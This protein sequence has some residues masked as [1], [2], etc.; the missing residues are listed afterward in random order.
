MWADPD[1]GPTEA[2]K[3]G[4]KCIY[5]EGITPEDLPGA[6]EVRDIEWKYPDQYLKEQGLQTIN[7]SFTKGDSSSNEVKQGAIGNCWFISAMSVL[8]SQDDLIR[9]G[10]DVISVENTSIIENQAVHE[11]SKGVFPPLFHKFAK[12][13]I[14]CLRFFKNFQWRYVIVDLKFPTVES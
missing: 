12:H 6:T 7:Y 10:G 4:G 2:Y 11:A 1:F 14:Y 3:H 13:G 5:Y 8:A 9:G